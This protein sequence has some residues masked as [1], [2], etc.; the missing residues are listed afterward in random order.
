M[1][2]S[3][4]NRT[5][6]TDRTDLSDLKYRPIIAARPA[7]FK[8]PRKAGTD[9]LFPKPPAKSGAAKSGDRHAFSQTAGKKRVSPRF[10]LGGEVG[11]L[12]VA[13]AFAERF[14]RERRYGAPC[15]GVVDVDA[16]FAVLLDHFDEIG[17]DEIVS[18]AV[19]GFLCFFAAGSPVFVHVLVAV[20]LP[21]LP[22]VFWADAVEV[23][24]LS[25]IV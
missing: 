7:Y 8:L 14:L 13:A 1:L 23:D 16:G 10:L 17:D 9:T 6:R 2:F 24:A 12:Y 5:D 4:P 22:L 15:G 11:E 19:S 25:G 20:C 18:A 21:F 3:P